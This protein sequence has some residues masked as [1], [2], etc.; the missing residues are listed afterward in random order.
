[1][2]SQ[3]KF[4]NSGTVKTKISKIKSVESA[5]VTGLWFLERINFFSKIINEEYFQS[6]FQ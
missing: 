1:M 4:S 5:N 2:N 6:S 3:M